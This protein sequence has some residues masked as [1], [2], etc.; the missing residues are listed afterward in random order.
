MAAYADEIVRRAREIPGLVNLQS[1]L[2]LNKPQL[3]VHVDREQASDLGVSVRDVAST[4]QVLL[5]GAELS[6]FK[7]HGETYEVI[8]Q[9]DRSDRANPSD[10]YGLYVRSESG[11]MV[12]LA[13]VVTIEETVTSSG[14][15][16]YDRQRAAGVSGNLLTGV[17]LG[18]TLDQLKAIGEAV[19]PADSGYRVSFSGLSERFY[20]SGSAL[21]FAYLLAVV[22]VYLV[23][24]AQ[25][26]SF[27]DPATILVAVALSFTG[28]LLALKAT[29]HTL[30]LFSQIGLVMLVGLVTKNSILIVEFANQLRERGSEPL[31]AVAQA[32]RT[33]FRP[34]MMTALSTIA[35]IMPIAIG[36]GRGR[37]GARTAR[38]CGG[39]GHGVLDTAHD[40]RHPH[41]LPR[42]RTPRDSDRCPFCSARPALAPG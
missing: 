16:H 39:G 22:M 34:V 42:I 37:R 2:K 14:L 21:G 7:M 4:L 30:N 18:E 25:F 15:P 3:I 32:A 20:Q 11:I 33:R 38:G 28:A 23:L 8:A 35:G 17:P 36:Y 41:R 24:A 1:D 12:P 6:T 27:V 10:L 13:S 9:I 19:I 40:L 5:G 26:E 29:G 31:E